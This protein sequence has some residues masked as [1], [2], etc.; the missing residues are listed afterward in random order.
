MKIIGGMLVAFLLVTTVAVASFIQMLIVLV[1][2]LLAEGLILALCRYLQRRSVRA[3]VVVRVPAAPVPAPR[4]VVPPTQGWVL[5]PV[6]IGPTQ[7]PA[8][9]RVIDA[10]VIDDGRHRW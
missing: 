10:G 6:W 8:A 9:P 2:Y 7:H 1:P 5:V 3:G 4:P